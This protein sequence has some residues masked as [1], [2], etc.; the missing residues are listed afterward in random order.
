MVDVE[1][2]HNAQLSRGQYVKWGPWFCLFERWFCLFERS[3][4]RYYVSSYS[5]RTFVQQ[6]SSSPSQKLI[7]RPLSRPW[8]S[9]YGR[10]RDEEAW[11]RDPEGFEVTI[12]QSPQLSLR[13]T[14]SEG[15]SGLLIEICRICAMEELCYRKRNAVV[16]RDLVSMMFKCACEG[17]KL[18]WD[19]VVKMRTDFIPHSIIGSCLH[20][21]SVHSSARI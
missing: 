5:L 16:L 3:L 7:L 9:V 20:Y 6:A 14:P 2:V 1:S 18:A 13:G 10:G 11:R 12:E 4:M 19:L 15:R 21:R 17:R 8:S